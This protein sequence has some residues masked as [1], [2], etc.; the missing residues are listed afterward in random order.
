MSLNSVIQSFEICI[1]NVTQ[2]FL[3]VIPFMYEQ[4][5]PMLQSAAVKDHNEAA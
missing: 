4:G 3:D 2:L 1:Y 5:P